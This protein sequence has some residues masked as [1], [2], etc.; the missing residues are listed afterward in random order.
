MSGK[1]LV[2]IWYLMAVAT[3]HLYLELSFN[4][5]AHGT[6]PKHLYD[7]KFNML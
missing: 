7:P 3:S 2:I 1:S 4:N 5:S 6:L